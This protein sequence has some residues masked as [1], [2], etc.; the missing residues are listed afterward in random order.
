[1]KTIDKIITKVNSKYGAPIGRDNIGTHP[2]PTFN[3]NKNVFDCAVPMS[4]D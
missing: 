2:N 1:M 4:N 3:L